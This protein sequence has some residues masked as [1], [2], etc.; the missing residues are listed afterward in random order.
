MKQFREAWDRYRTWLG[1]ERWRGWVEHMAMVRARSQQW[2][3]QKVGEAPNQHVESV[4]WNAHVTFAPQIRSILQ[5]VVMHP[6]R[7]FRGVERHA[8][9][10]R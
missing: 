3:R 2:K 5:K 9:P 7:G 4:A 10:I 1:D 8:S 6:N